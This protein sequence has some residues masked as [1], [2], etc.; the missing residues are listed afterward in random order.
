MSVGLA[1]GLW[2]AVEAVSLYPTGETPT[3]GKSHCVDI[4]SNFEHANVKA[5]TNLEFG[6][7]FGVH[8][9]QVSEQVSGGIEMTFERLVEFLYL[10]ETQLYS[11]VT[12]CEDG[13]DLRHDTWTHLNSSNTHCVAILGKELSHTY[14]FTY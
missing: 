12:V 7:I 9:P 10:T 13:L 6:H 11:V 5:L 1:V 8:L 14:L 3:L 2:S 4:L